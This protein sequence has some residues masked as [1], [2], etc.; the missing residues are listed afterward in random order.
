MSSPSSPAGTLP[1]RNSMSSYFLPSKPE[2]GGA[3]DLAQIHRPP[4]HYDPNTTT[5]MSPLCRDPLHAPYQYHTFEN[6]EAPRGAVSSTSV[7]STSSQLSADG[8][9]EAMAMAGRWRRGT[10]GRGEPVVTVVVCSFLLCGL[11]YLMA[12]GLRSYWV[13]GSVTMGRC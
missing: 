7:T 11:L 3:N 12:S 6:L 1:R 13:C 2:Q 8:G 10:G 5:L 9:G 4:P